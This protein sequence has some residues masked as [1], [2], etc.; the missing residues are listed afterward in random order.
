[1]MDRLP[2]ETFGSQHLLVLAITFT[3]FLVIPFLLRNKSN[4]TKYTAGIAIATLIVV[5]EITSAFNTF[6]F[7]HGWV[8]AFPLH[9]CDLSAFS[10]AYYFWKREKIFFNL[11][12]FWGIG[13]ATMALITPDVKFAWPAP[14][15]LPFFYGHGLV[16][17]GVFFACIALKERSYFS[18]IH[19][20]VGITLI[21]MVVIY[22]INLL[23]G[24][25]ANFWY[26]LDRPAGE[27]LMDL[28]P[29]PPYHLLITTPIGIALFYII[30]I[31]L[32]I[33]Y[34]FSK[35]AD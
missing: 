11:A 32:L 33:K 28:F 20:V 17:L 23:L 30:Y 1:M 14:E 13:G 22:C 6:S 29:D 7:D 34:M 3:V 15:F 8:E 2:F 12:F 10:I 24:N 9:M 19:K 5:H 25:G 27:S 16:L 35:N 21:L 26:L 18:D 4:E 31:P